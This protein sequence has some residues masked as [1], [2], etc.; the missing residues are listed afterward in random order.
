MSIINNKF[1]LLYLALNALMIGTIY[2]MENKENNVSF[3]NQAITTLADYWLSA[4]G[5]MQFVQSPLQVQKAS[6][7]LSEEVR[8]ELIWQINHRNPIVKMYMLCHL[9]NDDNFNNSIFFLKPK[10]IEDPKQ[11]SRLLNLEIFKKFDEHLSQLSLDQILL[12]I[13]ICEKID[14]PTNCTKPINLDPKL[15]KIFQSLTESKM[16]TPF[17]VTLI[18]KGIVSLKEE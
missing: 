2:N 16:G 14:D 5:R 15:L 9:L 10:I 6:P 1:F 12:L 4:K 8:K 13:H 17:Y 7:N 11:N 3:N 18:K